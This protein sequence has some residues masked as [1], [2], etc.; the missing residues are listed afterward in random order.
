MTIT[1]NKALTFGAVA[2]AGF[3]LWVYWKNGQKA[4]DQAAVQAVSAFF[5]PDPDKPRSG[6]YSFDDPEFRA[7]LTL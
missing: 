4:A 5:G 3:A 7:M 2:F 6:L 1:T